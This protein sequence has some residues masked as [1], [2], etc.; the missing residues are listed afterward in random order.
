[1]KTILL[2]LAGTIPLIAIIAVGSYISSANYGNS[3]ETSIKATYENNQNIL[4]QYGEKIVEAA[5]VPDMYRED[6]VKVT[7]SAISG[8]Y[9]ATGSKAVFQMIKEQNPQLD[10]K[11]YVQIQEIIESGR[12]N[13]QSAQSELIDKRRQYEASLGFVWS[14]FWLRLAGYPKTDMSK[15]YLPVNTDRATAIFKSGVDTPIKIR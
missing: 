15:N 13:F 7:A 12:N 10:S 3:I 11:L 6:V 1:M 4:S 8:R 9:G 14:G 5:Q 2:I